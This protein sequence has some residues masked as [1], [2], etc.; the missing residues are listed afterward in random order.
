MDISNYSSGMK[1]KKI[2]K[3]EIF[4]VAN[5]SI[6]HEDEEFKKAMRIYDKIIDAIVEEDA[7]L[8]EAYLITT[9]IAESI[10]YYTIFGE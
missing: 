2:D 6:D 7:T 4:N 5:S 1:E 8:Q 10:Y 9:A 3:S